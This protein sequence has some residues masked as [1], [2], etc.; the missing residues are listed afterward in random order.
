MKEKICIEE[1]ELHTNKGRRDFLKICSVVL[2]SLIGI[3]Y[4]VPLIRTFISPALQANS[5]RLNRF[6]RAG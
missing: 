6:D 5:F 3:A 1:T 2:S 4:A